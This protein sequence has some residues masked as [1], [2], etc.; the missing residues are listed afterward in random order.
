MNKGRSTARRGR[1]RAFDIE[2]A[3]DRAVRVFWQKGYE[4]AS[5]DDLTGAMGISRPSL[6]AAFGDKE[7]LFRKALDRY[8][9]GPSAFVREA[10]KEPTARAVVEHLL[11]GAVRSQTD[12]DTPPGCLMVHGALACGEGAET[13]RRELRA[14]RS[15]DEAALRRRLVRAKA[16][17]DLP[18]EA[19]PADLARYVVT[20]MRGMAV[21]AAGGASGHALRRVVRLALRAWPQ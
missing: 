19:N 17:G 9:E 4:G 8:A 18:L 11:L 16:E 21:E 20:V 2:E 7:T 10:L 1:P 13:I 12:P 14:R 6:Y 5:L 3:L 15:A